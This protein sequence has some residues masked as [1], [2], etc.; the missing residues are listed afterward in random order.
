MKPVVD[1]FI[2]NVH[3]LCKSKNVACRQNPKDKTRLG[4]Y[5]GAYFDPESKKGVEGAEYQERV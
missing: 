1:G 3:T 4:P 2:T 5:F